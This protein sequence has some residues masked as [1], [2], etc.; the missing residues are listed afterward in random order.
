[1]QNVQLRSAAQ[2]QKSALSW[3]RSFSQL[4]AVLFVRAGLSW[5]P[6]QPDTRNEVV[7][8]VPARIE[9]HEI[10]SV[11]GHDNELDAIRSVR[12]RESGPEG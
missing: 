5:Y 9:K 2:Q 7:S 12:V 4:A 3:L 1:M 10:A 6:Q 8:G 11:T